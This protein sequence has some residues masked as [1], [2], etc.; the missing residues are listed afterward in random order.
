MKKNSLDRE[1]K[2]KF[3]KDL[4]QGKTTVDKHL[5]D[6]NFIP[7]ITDM[8]VSYPGEHFSMRTGQTLNDKEF[9]DFQN[10]REWLR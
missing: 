9:Q 8:W 7:A 10:S 4:Q 5:Q 1:Q 6:S 3:I 2:L